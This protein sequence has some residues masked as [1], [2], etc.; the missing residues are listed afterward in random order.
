MLMAASC[1]RISGYMANPAI[2][3][4]TSMIDASALLPAES[5]PYLREIASK[6][7]AEGLARMAAAL[8]AE[9]ARVARLAKDLLA[10]GDLPAYAAVAGLARV[11]A[12]V[13]R[14][15]DSPEVREARSVAD[16]LEKLE[17]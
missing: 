13:A 16:L 10:T 12:I 9:P 15:G 14:R 1:G 3:T 8:D 11:P 17:L 2:H 4:V 5:K 7:D 6:T